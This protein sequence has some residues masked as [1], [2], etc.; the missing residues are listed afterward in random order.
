MK[1]N[2]GVEG[3]GRFGCETLYLAVQGSRQLAVKLYLAVQL[4]FG[5]QLCTLAYKVRGSLAVKLFILAY[6]YKV[7]DSWL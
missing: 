7:G 5:V 1:L 3:G 6:N 4:Y 2:L